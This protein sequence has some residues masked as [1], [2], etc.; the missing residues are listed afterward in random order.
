MIQISNHYIKNVLIIH[1][2]TNKNE[3]DP[4]CVL[5]GHVKVSKIEK[6]RKNQI[7]IHVLII[8]IKKIKLVL[9]K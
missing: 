2:Q 9:S 6:L 8:H 4:T 5:N 3:N 7:N 1:V